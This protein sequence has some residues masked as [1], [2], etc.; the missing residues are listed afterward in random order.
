[1]LPNCL[2]YVS[3]C[4]GKSMQD[5]SREGCYRL[6]ISVGPTCFVLQKESGKQGKMYKSYIDWVHQ[7][8]F[9]LACHNQ[10]L[11]A[12]HK[13]RHARGGGVREDVTV[14]ERGGQEHVTS[15]LY[16]FYHTYET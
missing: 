13:V 4:N 6:Q 8:K 2:H 12:V 14:C 1:M 16:I 3:S 10:T 7:P 5:V 9:C 15:R 11:G